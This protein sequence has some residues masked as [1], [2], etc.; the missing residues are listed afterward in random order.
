MKY[1]YHIFLI[2][3]I[4]PSCSIQNGGLFPSILSEHEIAEGLK[5]ALSLGATASIKFLNSKDG[6]YR[7]E[8]KILLPEQAR[9]LTKR[10]AVIPGFETLEETLLEKINRA[11]EDAVGRAGK[12]FA[13]AIK[14]MSFDDALKIL[15]GEKNAATMY[16]K[17]CCHHLCYDSFH[18]EIETSLNKIGALDIWKS[19]IQTYNKIPFVEDMNPSLDD[20]V[21]NEA[22]KAMYDLISR[23]ELAIRTDISERS[24]DILKRVF[25]RQDG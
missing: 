19:A 8:Y 5:E 11:A 9:V 12:I 3:I 10:L 7:S 20:Y 14:D 15:L 25:R 17:S 2:I 1:F 16:L 6:F 23:K 18:P 22:L 24:S 21:T 4:W 13:Q